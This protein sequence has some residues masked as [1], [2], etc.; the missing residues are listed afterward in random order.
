MQGPLSI[1][2]ALARTN[3]L[4]A[5]VGVRRMPIVSTLASA[6]FV[7]V[8]VTCSVTGLQLQ[9][10]G[11]INRYLRIAGVESVEMDVLPRRGSDD[12]YG[13]LAVAAQDGPFD[14]TSA[15]L[16]LAALAASS[17]AL[18][19]AVTKHIGRESAGAGGAKGC[20]ARLTFCFHLVDRV[21][22]GETPPR[23]RRLFGPLLDRIQTSSHHISLDV[24]L[25]PLS[26]GR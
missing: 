3:Q 24:I 17:R 10:H 5:W 11:P 7:T 9:A 12:L 1:S 21:G 13:V 15:G 19:L 20:H 25:R 26:L 16:D 14:V 18:P 23:R 2:T 4:L 22:L 8:R 6:M